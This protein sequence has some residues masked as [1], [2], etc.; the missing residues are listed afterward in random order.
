MLM[1]SVAEPL[2]PAAP[3]PDRWMPGGLGAA[4]APAA[5]LF[6]APLG[7][8]SARHTYSKKEVVSLYAQLKKASA[9]VLPRGV[10]RSDASLFAEAGQVR[11]VLFFWWFSLRT[12]WSTP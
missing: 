11:P 2:C 8:R 9:L 7:S 5:A 4:A 1:V 10:D 12:W 3:G 6:G